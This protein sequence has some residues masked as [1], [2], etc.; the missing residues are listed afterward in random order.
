M[1]LIWVSDVTVSRNKTQSEIMF[2]IW[3]RFKAAGI[4]IPYPQQELTIK[5]GSFNDRQQ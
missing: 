3:H 2:D 1:L 5:S 4:E